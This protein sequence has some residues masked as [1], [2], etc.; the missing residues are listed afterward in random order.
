[1]KQESKKATGAVRSHTKG[2]WDKCTH[3]YAESRINFS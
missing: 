1:M 2:I 3:M